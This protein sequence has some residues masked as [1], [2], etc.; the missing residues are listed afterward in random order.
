MEGENFRNLQI[1]SEYHSLEEDVVRDFFIPVLECAKK[2]DRA[3]GF[4]SSSGLAK[5]T[6]GICALV[7]NGGKIR[8]IASPDLSEEDVKAIDKGYK[9]RDVVVR[10]SLLREL[11][12]PD[13]EFEAQR[14]NLLANL[15][16]TGVLDI[17]I[18][19]L[20]NEAGIF[21]DKFGI[22]ADG[23]DNSI[24]FRGS[25]NES[26]NAYF[27]NYE[28]IDVYTSWVD[29]DRVESKQKTFDDLW[30]CTDD[31]VETEDFSDVKDEI[32]K[33][34]KTNG[35]IDTELDRRQFGSVIR[36]HGSKSWLINIPSS[37]EI[38]DYQKDAVNEWEK[39]DFRG[40]FD[41]ATGTGK[42][43]TA[44]TALERFEKRN[45]DIFAIV[46]C[47]Y[48]HLVD[49]WAEDAVDWGI[50]PIICHSQSPLKDWRA[51]LK[52]N[53][54]RYGN[55]KRS[56]MCI[57][58]NDTFADDTFQSIITNITDNM[59]AVLV[60]DEVH[61]FGAR[62]LAELM[63]ENIKYRLGLSATVERYGDAEGTKAIFDY[64]GDKCIEYPLE[65]A[66]REGALVPY[67]Y[68][69]VLCALTQ[70]EEEEYERLTKQIMS[71]F[72]KKNGKEILTEL[73]KTLS[74][75]RTRIVA[76]AEEKVPT[77]KLLLKDMLSEKHILVYCGATRGLENYK[78]EREKQID[79]V[80]RMIGNDLG[81][82]THRFTAE[83][84]SNTRRLIKEGF[85]NGDYQV[86]TA[87]KCL[88]EG[89]NIP[90]IQIACIL[91]SSKNPKEFIQRRGRVLRRAKGKN[92]AVIYDFVTL[93]RPLGQIKFGDFEKDKTMVIRE[94]T[95]VYE[96]G[97][98][99]INSRVA[100]EFM[101]DIS[102]AYSTEITEDDLLK[103]LEDNDDNGED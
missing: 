75:K 25:M 48:I 37:V 68:Y 102:S 96:F 62:S 15:I 97:R 84:D 77:L 9:L 70:E 10:E 81:M 103:G 40:I 64:F 93:P 5:Q 22:F 32:V 19:L 101:E 71:Q 30:N 55:S 82:S 6:A 73:G 8:L 45:G 100:D 53:Y 31:Q 51:S 76:G 43:F 61:N 3:A 20:K 44:L 35:N 4:F 63:P 90:N 95:R 99:S 11:K 29:L 74:Y 50:E 14:L 67:E 2:Y 94:L 91:A 83:E 39:H 87:I 28:S 92:R 54:R 47:P 18:A 24:A 78:G 41:M 17:K 23:E 66:I 36:P 12:N 16:A 57:V 65:K 7:R 49:Q 80:E 56:F 33:R 52:R 1:S 34:Y 69:P 60:V 13:N 89:V 38:R 42:T 27:H 86:V 58:T 85:A 21:H 79:I 59:N 26:E 46:V 98:F 88:D 72:V